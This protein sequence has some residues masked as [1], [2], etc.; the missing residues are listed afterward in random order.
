[1]STE[2]K[3]AFDEGLRLVDYWKTQLGEKDARRGARH[4]SPEQVWGVERERGSIRGGV[5]PELRYVTDE[6]REI[7]ALRPNES[8]REAFSAELPDGIQPEELSLGRY[9][10]AVILG[11]FSKARAEQRAMAGNS[12]SGTGRWT[13]TTRSPL[14][15]TLR[16]RGSTASR[17]SRSC[18]RT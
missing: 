10:R 15:L 3:T 4:V 7:R 12:D 13:I 17:R 14:T 8:I 11:D 6:G 2:E 9:I 16:P 5:D 18:F 1:M